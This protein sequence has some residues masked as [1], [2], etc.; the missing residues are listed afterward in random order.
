M[1]ILLSTTAVGSLITITAYIIV[2]LV[3]TDFKEGIEMNRSIKFRAWL[4]RHNMMAYDWGMNSGLGEAFYLKMMNH[5]ND[6]TAQ[7][8]GYDLPKKYE[9]YDDYVFMQYTGLL[10]RNGT[11]IYEGDILSTDLDRPYLIVEFRNGAFMFQCHDGGEDYYD[12]MTS[13]DENSN[14]TKYHEV[15]GNIHE[16]PHLLE[17]D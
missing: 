11:E 16:H 6:K 9:F 14:F 2:L 5:V 7:A 13:T 4:P 17:R 1:L 15:I 12:F 3:L 10:D 8:N